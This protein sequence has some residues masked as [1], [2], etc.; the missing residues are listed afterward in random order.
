VAWVFN[1]VTGIIER[2][3]TVDGD[4]ITDTLTAAAV[5]ADLDSCDASR[6]AQLLTG[7]VNFADIAAQPDEAEAE[8]PTG[9]PLNLDM[10]LTLTSANHPE[11]GHACF[12]DSPLEAVA[13]A[14]PVAY[15]C[16]IYMNA[17]RRWAG[18]L[19]I[20]PLAFETPA[21]SAAWSVGT[22]EV[23]DGSFRVVCR[24]TTLPGDGGASSKNSAHPLVYTLA[25][26]AAG[27]A[28][29]DQNFLVI[30]GTHSCPVDALSDDDLVN[31]N[32]RVHQNG[33]QPYI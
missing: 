18:R 12:D 21:G 32:T 29:R 25:G 31:A 1:N 15:F 17:D 7:F 28:L 5:A 2:T 11:P 22:N 30:R 16:A 33:N 20:T 19:R 14:R 13:Q 9:L 3:C 24:Y 10:A 8:A 6:T 26:S 4:I 27:A 23:A